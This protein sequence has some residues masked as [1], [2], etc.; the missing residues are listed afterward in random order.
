MNRSRCRGFITYEFCVGQIN[1]PPNIGRGLWVVGPKSWVVGHKLWVVGSKSG[2]VGP[3]SWVVGS[4]FRSFGL[5]YE[6]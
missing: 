3:K 2:V 6:E 5:L 4:K 1:L